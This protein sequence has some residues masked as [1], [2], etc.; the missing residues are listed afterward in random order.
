MEK[1]QRKKAEKNGYCKNSPLNSVWIFIQIN[2]WA[3]PFC[4]SEIQNKSIK[5]WW[6]VV[7]FFLDSISKDRELANLFKSNLSL[8]SL[9]YAEAY[10]KLVGPIYTSLCLGNTAPIQAKSNDRD[11][12][13]ANKL[14][15]NQRFRYSD[16]VHNF[17]TVILSLSEG[18]GKM[19]VGI[20]K[21]AYDRSSQLIGAIWFTVHLFTVSLSQ[22][23]VVDQLQ[24]K[25]Y[26]SGGEPSATR[27]PIWLSQ[28]LNLRPSAPETNTL[29]LN[30]L[31]AWKLTKWYSIT[32]SLENNTFSA[33]TASM[34]NFANHYY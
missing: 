3:C 31:A 33:T 6:F 10:N 4:C 5:R 13:T 11:K 9:Y 27:C 1:Q 24:S 19:A 14:T 23:V 21:Y 2:R 15:A 28:D 18:L 12:L 29:S 20:V 25:K 22:S 34:Y 32:Q 17:A 30:Q 26:C 8:H 16:L 7:C